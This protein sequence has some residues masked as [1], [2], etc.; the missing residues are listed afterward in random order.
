MRK[1]FISVASK[2]YNYGQQMRDQLTHAGYRPWLNPRQGA[3]Q[4]TLEIDEAIKASDGIIVIVTPNMVA[5][6]DVTY[7]WAYA[8]GLEKPIIN[9]IFNHAN[10]HPKLAAQTFFDTHSWTDIRHFWEYFLAELQKAIPAPVA[11]PP[12]VD[13]KPVVINAPVEL[14]LHPGRIMP[15]EP[16]FW[17]VVRKGPHMNQMFRLGDD[18]V[19]LGRDPSNTIMIDSVAISRHHCRFMYLNN[20]YSVEDV[21]SLNGTYING[22]K[23]LSQARLNPGDLI[24]LG[25]AVVI[26][27]EVVY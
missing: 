3:N 9:V 26:S 10:I 7:E 4:W 15:H 8:M 1:L 5:S 19:S 22:A 27:Y 16:G 23:V 12:L 24:Y 21:K 18:I 17:L 2:D 13:Q 11:K 25:D 6:P 14:S 20:G